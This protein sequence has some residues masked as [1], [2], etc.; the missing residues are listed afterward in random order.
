MNT[1]I[2]LFA[3]VLLG[4]LLYEIGWTGRLGSILGAIFTPEYMTK[5]PQQ[6]PLA[7]FTGGA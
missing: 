5:T 1:G 7:P 4:V 2:R 3:M 6:G